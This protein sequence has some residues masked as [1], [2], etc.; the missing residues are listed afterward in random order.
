MLVLY[1]WWQSWLDYVNQEMLVEPANGS[2]ETAALNSRRRPPAIYNNDLIDDATSEEV[3]NV[4]MELHDTLVEGRDY[5][6]LPQPVWE[7]LHGWF[8]LILFQFIFLEFKLDLG[9]FQ[10][11]LVPVNYRVFCSKVLQYSNFILR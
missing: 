3:S 5:I 8:V 7:K 10:K 1:R 11:L 4:E 2:Y 9:T 6:L